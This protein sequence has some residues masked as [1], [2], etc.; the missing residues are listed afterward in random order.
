MTSSHL[1]RFCKGLFPSSYIPSSQGSI[2]HC[3]NLGGTQLS[4][5][6]RPEVSTT[7]L[8]PPQGAARSLVAAQGRKKAQAAMRTPGLLRAQTLGRCVNS[9]V[10]L[11]KVMG[12]GADTCLELGAGVWSAELA[13]GHVAWKALPTSS[14]IFLCFPLLSTSCPLHHEQL[15]APGSSTTVPFLP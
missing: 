3:V 14:L 13:P 6:Q 15:P 1:N 7:A 5:S 8:P 11:C 2:C 12:H 9:W 4:T 10:G